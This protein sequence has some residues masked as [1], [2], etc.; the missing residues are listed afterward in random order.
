MNLADGIDE[1][2][3]QL[4]QIELLSSIR[5]DSAEFYELLLAKEC[6]ITFRMDGDRKHSRAH[7][8]IDIGNA[9]HLASYAVDTGERLTPGLIDRKCEAAVRS[10]ISTHR[11]KLVA[12]F[13]DLQAGISYDKHTIREMFSDENTK[14]PVDA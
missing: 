4:Q 14:R 8:H 1:L 5:N 7:I 10:F 9:R 12:M 11:D 3:R 6:T 2:E 13:Y